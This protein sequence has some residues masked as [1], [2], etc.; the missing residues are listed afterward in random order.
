MSSLAVERGYVMNDT[1]PNR[2]YKDSLF[3]TY[4]AEDSKRLIEVYN[5]VF[6]ADVPP[7]AE[8]EI[9]TLENVLY[10]TLNNDLSFTLG[11]NLVVLMEDQA[12][13][14]MNMP[15]R[16]LMYLAR[17][18]EKLLP[19]RAVYAMKTV[20]VP[21]PEFV[22]F[23]NGKDE[24]PDTMELKLSEAF[25]DA[26]TK[27]T[28]ELTVTMYNIN[29]GHNEHI[30]RRSKSLRDYSTFIAKIHEYEKDGMTLAEAIGAGVNYC[31][32]NGV[33]P[34]FIK[35]H[36]SEVR[37]MLFVEYDPVEARK[38]AMEEGYEDGFEQG[39]EQ[40]IEQ[41]DAIA[42]RENAKRMKAEGLDIALIGKITDLSAEEIEK[43]EL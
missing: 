6:G 39:I 3:V 41:G 20:K 35:K 23:Y 30:R 28:L 2:Q 34:E 36:A 32:E 27:E 42:R 38:V 19:S 22:V 43:I 40:G 14:N 31:I 10:Q 37:N 11:G 7:D 21:K 17:V 8:I 16:L 18:Y 29:P 26:H 4:L 24:M 33:M 9:N 1:K 13:P 5:A 25:R 12:T 15:L